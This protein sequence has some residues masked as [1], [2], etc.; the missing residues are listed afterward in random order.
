MDLFSSLHLESPSAYS[1]LLGLCL[2]VVVVYMTY[3]D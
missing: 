3:H 2:Q 1:H